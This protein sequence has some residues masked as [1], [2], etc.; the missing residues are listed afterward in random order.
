MSKRKVGWKRW[1]DRVDGG[2]EG[3]PSTALL[4]SAAKPTNVK[5]RQRWGER[6]GGGG[7]WASDP[8]PA[9]PVEHPAPNMSQW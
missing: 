7:G 4:W 2:G 8:E 9:K 1:G 3:L 5:E 6:G